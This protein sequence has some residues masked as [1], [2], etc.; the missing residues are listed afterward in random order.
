MD[1]GTL[2]QLRNL[3]RRTQVSEK[4]STNVSAAED[5]LEV[6][7]QGHVIAA[8]MTI[9]KVTN[10]EDLCL[11]EN[12]TITSLS[13]LIIE[14]FLT[15]IFFGEEQLTS[16]RVNLYGRELLLMGLI[17]YSFKDAIAEGDGPSVMCYWKV[18]TIIFRLTRHTK[19][20]NLNLYI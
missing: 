14:E 9:K 4:V 17:W 1:K 13:Q 19:Y 5:L 10:L 16:D 8:A 20:V 3:L 6:V 11:E 2:F 12:E 7:T 15:P 18:M